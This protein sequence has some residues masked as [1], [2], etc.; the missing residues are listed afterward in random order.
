MGRIVD[1]RNVQNVSIPEMKPAVSEFAPCD[2]G[3]PAEVDKFN[4]MIRKLRD[5]GAAVYWETDE[6]P[7]SRH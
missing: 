6:R 2:D 1:H 5:Q 4:E 3:D 7:P